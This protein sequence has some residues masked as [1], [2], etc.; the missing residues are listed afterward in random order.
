M[1]NARQVAV[2][3]LIIV[4]S[5]F[6]SCAGATPI[7]FTFDASLQTGPL[8]GTQFSG[9][10]SYDNQGETGIGPEF[11]PLTSL[12][13]SLLGFPFTLADISQGGQAILQDGTLSYFTAAFFPA[14][15][16]SPVNDIAFGF[17]GPGIIG[18]STPPGF[19]FGEGVYTVTPI[20]EPPTLLLCCIALC[21]SSF[22]FLQRQS[23]NKAL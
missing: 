16:P 3:V 17:G 20:P 14:S 8:S 15:P 10:A 21:C 12:N 7:P 11:L 19:N 1:L 23:A 5:A 6:V 18:Y 2:A 9:T 22:L 13:F 4:L